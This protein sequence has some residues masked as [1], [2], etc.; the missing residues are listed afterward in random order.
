MVINCAK[1]NSCNTAGKYSSV[2]VNVQRW[3][4]RKQKLIN[5][6]S[7]RKSSNDPKEGHF[8]QSEQEIAAFVC[9]K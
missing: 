3:K 4:E 8:Q 9:L 7:T 1:K 2:A 6:N 5:I